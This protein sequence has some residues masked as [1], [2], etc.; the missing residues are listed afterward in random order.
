MQANAAQSKEELGAPIPKT[1][2][3]YIKSFGPGIVIV[4]TWLGA[5]DLVDNAIAGAHY[6]YALMWGLVIALIVRYALTSIIANYQLMN[7]Q[8]H[9]LMDGYGR[10]HPLYPIVLGIGGIA[11]GHFYNSYLIKGA[12][13]AI[14][15]LTG[16]V[17]S[18]LFWSVIVVIV[19]MTISG[20]SVYKHLENAEKIILALMALSLIGGAIAVGPNVGAMAKGTVAFA[21]PEQVG[22]FGAITIVV[23]LIGSVG[24]SLANLLYPTFMREKGWIRPEHRKV[25]RYDLMFG[26]LMIILLDLSVWVMGAE[27]LHPKGITIESFNDLARLLGEFIGHFGEVLI[28]LGVFG[29]CFSGVLGYA[30]GFPKMLMDAVYQYNPARK[31]KYAEK[32][33]KDPIYLVSYLLIAVVPLI[34]AIPGMPGFIWLT[35]F[36]NAAQIALLPLV[37]IGLVIL[38]NRKDLMGELAGNK[39]H[40]ILLV[41]LT[42]LAIWGAY[43]TFMGLIH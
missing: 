16:E 25:Q 1:F 10:I 40:N 38:I 31:E 9:N 3:E 27:V 39:I 15:H 11:L 6:G 28:Y 24:G 14:Y 23:S 29:A 30:A 41:L 2:K 20:R 4:L 32:P 13:E 19:G 33:A 43:Q 5:G 26:I 36:V 21:V 8:G 7:V 22:A 37:S 35:V 18:I 17:G 12:G 34:W 42:L